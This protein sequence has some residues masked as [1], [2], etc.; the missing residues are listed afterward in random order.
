MGIELNTEQVYAIYDAETW[1]RSASASQIFEIS[2][3]A[4]SGKTTMILYF[5]ERMGLDINEDVLFVAFMGKAANQMALNGLPAKTIHSA[6][7]KYEKEYIRDQDG[8]I[9]MD[10]NGK[11]KTHKVMVKKERLDKKYK[12]IVL[13]EGSMVNDQLGQDLESYGIPMVVLGDLNQLPPVF[14]KPRYL[15][16]PDVVLTKVMRQAEGD[17]IIWL[18]QQVLAGNDL[19]VGVYGKSSVMD[20]RDIQPY[21]FQ[22]SSIVICCTNRLRYNVNNYFRES[23]KKIARLDYPHLGEKVV[24]RKNNWSK[25]IQNNYYLTNGTTG[26]VTDIDRSSYNGKTMKIDIRPDFSNEVFRNVTFDYHHLYALPGQEEELTKENMY[27]KFV[28]KIEYAYSLT[29]HT[30]Q[31]SQYPKVLFLAENMMR[32]KEDQK[33]LL[34]TGI[35]RAQTE[36]V[37]AI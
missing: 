20:R 35:T 16:H 12:L 10:K 37:V 3:P 1:F 22:K 11:A 5:I 27:L 24:C 26:F 30:T 7:Y 15:N 21:H 36:L 6:I 32:T 19:R 2:G 17:P 18:S 28:D 23:V 8:H 29:V 31:G 13:D 14:G 4:G 9:V 25:C 33:K 34:Y